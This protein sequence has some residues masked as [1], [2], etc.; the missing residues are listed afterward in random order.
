MA[1]DTILLG[2]FTNCSAIAFESRDISQVWYVNSLV[3][4]A[5]S[6]AP[7]ATSAWVMQPNGNNI[8][9]AYTPGSNQYLLSASMII[10]NTQG[11]NYLNGVWLYSS[12]SNVGIKTEAYESQ[13][14][15]PVNVGTVN[16]KTAWKHTH[17]FAG[18]TILSAGRTYL[19]H[20]GYNYFDVQYLNG[21]YVPAWSDNWSFATANSQTQSL[22]SASIETSGIYL[23]LVT[24]GA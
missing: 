17:K 12:A 10:D 22:T 2:N 21:G 5:T 24:S 19:F 1:T 23:E 3:W 4:S 13:N 15:S 9:A 16:G 7:P 8:V 18:T 20:I 6:G 11:Y 14:V